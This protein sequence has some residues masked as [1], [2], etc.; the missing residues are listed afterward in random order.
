[1]HEDI[2][3]FTGSTLGCHGVH[4]NLV[5]SMDVPS[6]IGST[7][8]WTCCTFKQGPSVLYIISWTMYYLLNILF[9]G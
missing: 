5:V 2:P 4:S 9:Y 6:F 1:M 3:S 7:H 8:T